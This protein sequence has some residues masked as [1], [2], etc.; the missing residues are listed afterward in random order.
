MR[1]FLLWGLLGGLLGGG[2]G[3]LDPGAPFLAPRDTDPPD[4]IS[5]EP[6]VGGVVATDGA[7][8]VLFSEAM[9]VRTLR[10]GM[11]VFE[12]RAEVPLTLKV[13]PEPTGEAAEEHGD[14]PYTVSVSPESGT[15]KAGSAYTLV[16][17]TSLTDV[18][19]NALGQEVRVPFRTPP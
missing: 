18:E 17:R 7:L 15:W 3:C 1:R 9:D 12:G 5:T 4:V 2:A 14:V 11:A 10:P 13:P 16:L 6:S 19:G 8:Q